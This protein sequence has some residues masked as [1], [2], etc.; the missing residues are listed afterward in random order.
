MIYHLL[1]E[2]DFDLHTITVSNLKPTEKSK[3]VWRFQRN[4]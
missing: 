3:L 2:P 4:Q 1:L